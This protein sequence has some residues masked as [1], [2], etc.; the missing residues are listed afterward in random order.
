MYAAESHTSINQSFL[1][2]MIDTWDEHMELLKVV[3]NKIVDQHEQPVFLRG[4]CL[5]GWMNMEDFINGYPGL[6][7]GLRAAMTEVLGA[8]KAEFF[9]DRWLDHFFSEKDIQFLKSIGCTVVRL[10]LNYRHFESDLAPFE[11]LEKGFSRL[12]QAVEC[13]GRYGLYV[14]FDLHAV[15]GWQNTDWHCDNASR[16][17]LFWSQKQYQDRFVALWQEFARR[18]K[19]NAVV[20]GYN[21]MNEPVTNAPRGL[22]DYAAYAPDYEVLN[23]VYQRVVEAIRLVDPDH[24]IFLEGDLFSARFDGMDDPASLGGNI[25]Y[26]SHNYNEAGFGP[27]VYPSV[28]KGWGMEW[29]EQVFVNASG[30]RFTQTHNVPLWVGEFGAAYNGP[31]GE[32]PNRLRALDDQLVVFNRHQAHWTIWVYKDIHVMGLMQVSQGS[33]YIQTIASILKGKQAVFADFW[34]RWA[35]STPVKDSVDALADQIQETLSDVDVDVKVDH[36]YLG[37]SVLSGYTAILMQPAFARLFAGMSETQLDGILAS[38]SF[39]NCRPHQALIETLKLHLN[40]SSG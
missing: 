23:K 35:A 34:M 14:I 22:F 13:C 29:Q 20:A 25:V 26:S 18:Y 32:I 30:T 3:G 8:G 19:G 15:Q 6:E 16:H 17:S 10:A 9:F 33:R 28:D 5:G 2:F 39:E 37:Q 7:S 27:G 1:I 38:F 31:L 36:R 12:D 21:V 24:I 11:Y 4:V 40:A